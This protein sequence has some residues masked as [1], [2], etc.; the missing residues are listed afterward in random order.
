MPMNAATLAAAVK[1]DLASDGF[2]FDVGAM[3]TKFIDKL[4]AAIVTHIQTN[5]L[6][7]GPVV[8]TSVSGVTT[9]PGV[10]GPGAGTLTAGTIT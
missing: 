5:A 3:N 10:S 4:C 8:V 2:I 6:V 9:G 1:A 7:A